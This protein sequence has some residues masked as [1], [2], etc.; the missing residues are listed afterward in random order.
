MAFQTA[1][2]RILKVSGSLKSFYDDIVYWE[3]ASGSNKF[4][5]TF[6]RGEYAIPNNK[7]ESIAT[8]QLRIKKLIE[9]RENSI[10]ISALK[11]Q[12]A[13]TLIRAKGD[14]RYIEVFGKPDTGFSL[15]IKDSSG[16]NIL[17]KF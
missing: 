16:C 10:G 14:R 8:K 17:K 12:N 9:E 1:Q 7:Q 13:S 6:M 4:F 11:V 5:V 15:T 2:Y 3:L